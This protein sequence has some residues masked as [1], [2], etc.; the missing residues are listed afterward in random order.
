M[1][2]VQSLDHFVMVVDNLPAAE[3]FF[4]EVLG[5]P[6]VM[7]L[8]LSARERPLGL[9]P[10][11]FV[12][13]A[14]T[15]IG[16]WLHHEV[17]PRPSGLRGPTSY[18]FQVTRDQ[19]GTLVGSLRRHGVAFEGPEQNPDDPLIAESLYLCDP[20]GNHLAFNVHR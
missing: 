19:M 4:V 12:E 18:G 2:Q 9:P 7:R 3:Q 13:M 6:I 20:S 14:G 5:A 15:R 1:P 10:H 16:L 11:T 17:L 8:G